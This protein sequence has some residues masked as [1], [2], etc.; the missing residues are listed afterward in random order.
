MKE[1]PRGNIETHLIMSE[2]AFLIFSMRH[3]G[4]SLG[5]QPQNQDARVPSSAITTGS[6]DSISQ[7]ALLV[8]LS[9]R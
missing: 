9:L 8:L 6:A 2:W 1:R 4:R 7:A 5:L 3:T